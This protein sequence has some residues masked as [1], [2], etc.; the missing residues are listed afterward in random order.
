M[1]RYI[2]SRLIQGV[3]VLLMLVTLA[4]FMAKALPGEPFT[5]EKNISEKV[6]E[7]KRKQW[8][9]DKPLAVQYF[10][11][12]KHMFVDWDFGMSTKRVRPVGL[13]IRQ[14]FPAS[15]VLGLVALGMAVVIGIPLGAL[16]AL[17]RNTWIDYL[18]MSFA[19]V[20]IC[21]ASFVIGSLL[22]RYVAMNVP[23]L[24]IAGWGTPQ[25]VILP[26]L[27]L[28][29]G[30]A[31]YLARLTRV[32]LLEILSQDYIRTAYAKGLSVSRIIIK[33]ALRGG[34]IPA[35][36]Y[37]GPAFASLISG[38][39]I[40]ETIF[41]VPGMGQH[42]VNAV[43]DRDEFLLLGLVVFYGFLIVVVNLLA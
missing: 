35:I 12:L 11:T 16:S 40:V 33:H 36:S 7:E 23:F 4:F 37:L 42:F 27:T 21:V 3:F 28:A 20:G 10:V 17:R 32:G 43:I 26:S 39:F 22:Q 24:N 30:P 2:T 31:A 14:S 38:S 6:K 9:L 34:L 19:M 1:L 29:L 8:G 13:I 15:L 41:S 18:G 5:G 25:D